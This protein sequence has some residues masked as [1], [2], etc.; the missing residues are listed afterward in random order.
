LMTSRGRRGREPKSW[1]VK[2]VLHRGQPLIRVAW[3]Y[4]RGPSLDAILMQMLLIT[5]LWNWI[6]QHCVI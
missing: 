1:P 3:K 2:G 5:K 4:A 6:T